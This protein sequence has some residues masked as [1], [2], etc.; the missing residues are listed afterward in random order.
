MNGGKADEMLLCGKD[1]EIGEGEKLKL[2]AKGLPERKAIQVVE[3]MFEESKNTG[4]CEY[5]GIC[6]TFRAKYP[7]VLTGDPT[8]PWCLETMA[9]TGQETDA[10]VA[11]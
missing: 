8:K 6:K 10:P 5:K 4:S 11:P 9:G 2:I 7:R 3:K 1:L